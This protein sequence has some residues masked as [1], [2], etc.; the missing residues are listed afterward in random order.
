MIYTEFELLDHNQKIRKLKINNDDC[1]DVYVWRDEWGGNTLKNPHWFKLKI[2]G[3]GRYEF[4]R[5]NYKTYQ[6]SRV[7]YY[8]NNPEWDIYD[9][10]SNNFIDHID[11]NKLN[12]HITNLRVVTQQQNSQ[13]TDAKGY[14]YHKRK[15]KYKASIM[16]DGKFKHIGYYDT[17]QEARENYL[18]YKKKYHPSYINI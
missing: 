7:V 3:Y 2:N 9:T 16:I 6:L 8:V 12:N 1:N 18:K 13:N 17:E 14:Y 11:R 5:V 10:S 4:I 15:N